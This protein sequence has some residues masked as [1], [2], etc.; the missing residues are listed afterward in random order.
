MAKINIDRDAL[1][2]ALLILRSGMPST[3]AVPADSVYKFKV[4][5]ESCY[6][7]ISNAAIEMKVYVKCSSDEEISFYTPN[8]I[9]EN[10]IRN[11]PEGEVKIVTTMHDK[12]DYVKSVHVSPKG[13]RK[14]YKIACEPYLEDSFPSWPDEIGPQVRIKINDNMSKFQ[15]VIKLVGANVDP[16][17]PTQV[18]QNISLISDEG[19]LKFVSG[20]SHL[21]LGIGT[22]H[23][24]EHEKVIPAIINKAISQLTEAG[25]TD[26]VVT[27]KILYLKYANL[28]MKIKMVEYKAPP[29]M[30]VFSVEPDKGIIVDR[31]ELLGAL[32]RMDGVG[33]T[34]NRV[35]LEVDGD[36]LRISSENI[37]FGHEGEEY[38]DIERNEVTPFRV[39]LNC[40]YLKNAVASTKSDNVVIKVVGDGTANKPVFM[41]PEGDSM[42]MK[43]IIM[44]H[45]TT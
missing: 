1:N 13:Q 9:L 33:M 19:K 5:K 29:Y 12:K 10:T 35:A 26:I 42:P 11:F 38:L 41:S 8:Y 28:E 20:N 39:L 45:A 18:Y 30:K 15:E 4:E 27:D 2:K 22:D 25:D 21:A 17:D 16:R 23:D 44:P 37:D 40:T 7:T 43:W 34:F 14:K 24:I 3:A 32:K 31:V 36:S 6:I